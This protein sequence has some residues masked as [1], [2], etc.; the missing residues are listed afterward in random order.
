MNHI[1]KIKFLTIAFASGISSYSSTCS[2]ASLFTK[3]GKASETIEKLD[4]ALNKVDPL[5]EGTNNVLHDIQGLI[6]DLQ[7]NQNRVSNKLEKALDALHGLFCLLC[8]W[9]SLHI[10]TLLMSLL[11]KPAHFVA[12]YFARKEEYCCENIDEV[13][14]R[15]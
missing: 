12:Q 8:A 5:A 6:K 4:Q 14:E 11:Q 1:R 9:V 7:Q 3:L 2:A 10:G 15:Y 13:G